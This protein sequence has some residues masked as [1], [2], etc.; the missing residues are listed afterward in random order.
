MHV[1]VV[2]CF[3]LR[4]LFC[5]FVQQMVL[6]TAEPYWLYALITTPWGPGATVLTYRLPTCSWRTELLSS[7]FWIQALFLWV[8]SV[9]TTLYPIAIYNFSWS[10]LY[11]VFDYSSYHSCCYALLFP[12]L[13]NSLFPFSLHY[14]A[15][16][17]SS[18]LYRNVLP[19][20]TLEGNKSTQFFSHVELIRP[21]I[22]FR[23]I[24]TS[25]LYCIVLEGHGLYCQTFCLFHIL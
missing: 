13:L 23:C 25:L 15:I 12:S 8:I 19:L 14:P 7:V 1:V 10:L 4:D 24:G 16:S 9:F 2:W 3:G 17:R 22:N 6:H 5:P 21:L 18:I 11:F 20:Q